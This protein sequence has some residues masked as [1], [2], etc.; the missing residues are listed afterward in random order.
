MRGLFRHWFTMIEQCPRCHLR[1]ERLPGH[2]LGSI[3]MNTILSFGVMA[4]ALV[5]SLV[6]AHP[7]FDRT[8]LL[9]INIPVA[10]T[11]PVLFLPFSKTIW[12][13]VELLGRPLAEGEV[14]A[15]YAPDDPRTS[16]SPTTDASKKAT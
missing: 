8:R 3:A 1:F 13:A 6:E 14:L 16:K 4:I 2:I 10:I 12:S 11:A 15:Q 5:W 9:L 7:N